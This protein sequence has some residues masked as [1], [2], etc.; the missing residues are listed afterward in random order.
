MATAGRVGPETA[1]AKL[2][3]SQQLFPE[4]DK[5]PSSQKCAQEMAQELIPIAV[6]K[7][8]C[9]F[10]SAQQTMAKQADS[11]SFPAENTGVVALAEAAAAMAAADQFTQ[12]VCRAAKVMGAEKQVLCFLSYLPLTPHHLSLCSCLVLVFIKMEP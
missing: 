3:Q 6:G 10:G 5:A 2:Q 11:D 1:S 4:E 7:E 9:T 8:E 12:D